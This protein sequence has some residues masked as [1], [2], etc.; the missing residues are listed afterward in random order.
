MTLYYS[1]V[2]H[3]LTRLILFSSENGLRSVHFIPQGD[4]L[5]DP[6]EYHPDVTMLPD[7]HHNSAIAQ[8]LHL[9]L[10]GV[11]VNFNCAFDLVG[12]PF[13][14]SVW[15]A[16]SKIPFGQTRTYG[17]LAAQIGSPSGSRAVGGA[18]GRNPISIIIP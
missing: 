14:K 1:F 6:G 9:Y 5:P 10:E 7:R 18:T 12:T 17:E 2:E 4:P 13:Q 11:P 15:T 3:P 8:Q 16:I